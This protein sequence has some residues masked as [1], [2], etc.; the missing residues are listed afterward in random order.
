MHLLASGDASD[1]AGTESG[2]Q[3][4]GTEQAR[5]CR[6]KSSSLCLYPRMPTRLLLPLLGL[7]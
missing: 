1:F 7:S 3:L 6:V 4:G 5:I 2:C